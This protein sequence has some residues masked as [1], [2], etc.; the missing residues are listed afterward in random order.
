MRN[1]KELTGLVAVAAV[2][3]LVAS[4]CSGGG[5]SPKKSTTNSSTFAECASTPNDCNGGPTKAG[6][7]LTY[8]IEKVI[9]GWNVNDANSSTFDFAEVLSGILPSPFIAYPD[10]SVKLNTDMMVS[11]EQTSTNPQTIVYKIKPDAVWDDGVP[12]SADDFIYAWQTQNGKDCSACEAASTAGYDQMKSVE[13]SDNGKT[14]TVVYDK[15]YTDWQQPF[16]TLYPAHIAKNKGDLATSWKAFDTDQPTY[17]GGPYKISDYQKDVSVTE[18]ANPKWYGK[19]KPPLDKL[20]FRIITDQSQEIPALQNNEVQSIYPQPNA[21]IVNQVKGLAPAVQ[22]TMNFGLNWEHFDL[23]LKNKFLADK[24]L[25]QAIFTAVSRQQII[26]KT[27]G[28][29]ASGAKPLD[30]HNYV[31]K[32]QGYKDVVTS[33]GQGSGDIDKAKKILTDAGYTGVGTALKTK[34]GEAV[35]PLRIR[36]TA[37]NVLRQQTCELF[38]S[39]MAQLGIKVTIEPTS[40]LGKTLVAGD[41]DVIIFAWVGAPFVFGGALQLWM[42]TSDSNYGHWVNPQSDKLLQDA[43]SQTD[44]TKAIDLLNQADQIMTDDAYVLPLFQKPTFLAVYSQFSNIRDNATSS[45]P[46]YNVQEWGLRSQ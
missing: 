6:G 37:G 38:Q 43:A 42:S 41:F 34:S 10:F 30:S 29:F 31:P 23:N 2:C 20:V 21:D 18:V 19:V 44:K 9:T 39:F 26:D 32:Q 25:R 24:P 12:I 46:P 35:P 13:G 36:Y 8:T 27:I 22:Y 4:A 7:T 15:P 11:A 16:G 33:T 14:V 40:G 1:S 5:N 3:V 17:T 28:Q 45:G